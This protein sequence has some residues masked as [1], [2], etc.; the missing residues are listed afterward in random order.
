ML[1][2]IIIYVVTQ[3]FCP[4]TQFILFGSEIDFKSANFLPGGGGS[5]DCVLYISCTQITWGLF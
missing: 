1:G 4:G 2:D 3:R 5:N